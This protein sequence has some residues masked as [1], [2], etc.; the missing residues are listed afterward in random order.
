MDFYS[1][2]YLV[3]VKDFEKQRDLNLA[4][5]KVKYLEKY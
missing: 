3:I 1:E 4:R 2:N 5:Q